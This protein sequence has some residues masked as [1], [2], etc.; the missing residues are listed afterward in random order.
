MY[1]GDLISLALDVRSPYLACAA[2]FHERA[3]RRVNACMEGGPSSRTFRDEHNF[4]IR[5]FVHR[6]EM[7]CERIACWC[8]RFCVSAFEVAHG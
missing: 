4:N 1:S 8:F 3:S 6:E 5:D 2:I 7:K